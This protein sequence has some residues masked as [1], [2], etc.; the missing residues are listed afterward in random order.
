MADD[1]VS[2]AH[3]ISVRLLGPLEVTAGGRPLAMGGPKQRAVVAVLALSANRIVS[4]TELASALWGEDEA[5]DRRHSLQQHVSSLRKLIADAGMT[6]E[7]SIVADGPGYRMV[8][9]AMAVDVGAFEALRATARKS[10]ADGDA[11]GAVAHLRQA[12]DLWRGY[13]LVDFV[14]QEWFTSRARALD[15]ERLAATEELVEIRLALGQQR[16]LV[17]ELESLVAAEPFRER[18]WAQL[19]LALYRSDRQAEALAAF[20][21]AR[22]ALVEEL[23]IEP[24][25]ALRDLESRILAQDPD[26]HDVSEPSLPNAGG[27]TIRVDGASRAYLELPGGQQVFLGIG[28]VVLGR[29]PDCEGRLD[30]GRVSRR[31]AGIEADGDHFVVVDLESTNGTL[32]NGNQVTRAAIADGDRISL[33][34]VEVVVRHP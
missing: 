27:E 12:V 23:G 25:E 10:L 21:R 26:L 1:G 4:I 16:Q 20:A 6:A 17:G 33:G 31:H 24:G 18:L 29:A 32:L 5:V 22:T 9:P 2:G 14:D 13:A 3:P 28:P 34:G 19:M 15:E 30:D 8:I 11:V 7:A